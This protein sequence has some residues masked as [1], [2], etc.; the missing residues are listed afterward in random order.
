MQYKNVSEKAV[1]GS[2]SLRRKNKFYLWIFGFIKLKKFNE[3][4][5]FYRRR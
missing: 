1:V 3:N 4:C 5:N 2:N